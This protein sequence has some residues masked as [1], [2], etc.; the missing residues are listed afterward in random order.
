MHELPALPQRAG[1]L[2]VGD[3]IDLYMAHYAGRDPT[4]VQR[5]TW[6]R[7]KVGQVALQDLSDDHLHAALESLEN[8][9]SRYWAGKDADGAPIYKAKRQP[10]APATIN[11]YGA[12]IAAVLTWSIKR[13]I[14]PKGFV[15]PSRAIE[16]KPEHNERTRF[17]SDGERE[18][19]L[20]ACRASA[21]PR[22]Y[23][24]VLL[25][26]TTGARKSELTGL[27]WGDVDLVRGVAYVGRSKNND[28]R[29]LPLVAAV[30]GELKPWQA[31]A[32]TLVFPSRG[33]P[34]KPFAFEPRWLEA[35]KAAKVRGFTFHALRHSCASMLAQNG[36]T[37]LEIADVL[38]HRQLQM[39][40]RYSHLATAHKAALVQRVLGEIK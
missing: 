39:T 16:R 2:P 30:L 7:G 5:L 35:L 6:W 4:R 36:A 28:P 33:Q 38:G 40:K 13:R 9:P 14:A 20:A 1:A 23:A 24:L 18:R 19:L 31:G 21:W 32:S 11:R 27:R 29:V 22:L 37:L 15:H 10:L 34:D 12:S 26:L 3:L 25:A 17:L 8:Q